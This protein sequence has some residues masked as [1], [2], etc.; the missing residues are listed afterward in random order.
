MPEAEMTIDVIAGADFSL[1]SAPAIMPEN[2][3]SIRAGNCSAASSKQSA[4]P[5]Y[6]EPINSEITY[7]ATMQTIV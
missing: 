4:K 2:T 1:R 7:P 6:P 5:I 3:L